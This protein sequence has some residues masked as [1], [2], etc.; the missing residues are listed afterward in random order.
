[1][2]NNTVSYNELKFGNLFNSFIKENLFLFIFLKF[3]L[4]KILKLSEFAFM[5]FALD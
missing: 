5:V 4:F 2:V 3:K 1:M